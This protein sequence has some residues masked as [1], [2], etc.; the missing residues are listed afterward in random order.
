MR[1]ST[2][3]RPR[4]IT[5]IGWVF[6]CVGCAS[7]VAGLLR[8]VD[9]VGFGHGGESHAQE[10]LDLSLV[11][12]SGLLAVVSGVYV[13]RGCNWARW[14][15]VVW[16]GFHVILSMLHSVAELVVHGVL[17]AVLSCVLFLPQASAYFRG[18]PTLVKH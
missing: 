15:C 14:L 3:Q 12:I 7:V 5:A 16:M 4:P 10:L 2:K 9:A 18:T 13:L 11:P 17:F 1:P 6:I 8:F